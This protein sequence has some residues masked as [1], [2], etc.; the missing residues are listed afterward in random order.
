MSSETNKRLADVERRIAGA[1]SRSGRKREEVTLVAVSKLQ[2][3][4]RV[5]DFIAA[6]Q[7]AGSAVV[8]GENYVQEADEKRAILPAAGK[9][10]MIG[11]LQSNKARRAVAIFDCIETVD[12]EKLAFMLSQ[13]AAKISRRPEV[14]IQVNISG[15]RR[16]AGVAPEQALS[17]AT[18]IVDRCSSV[19]LR[20][21]MTITALHE[22]A[23]E[24]RADFRRMRELRDS[25]QSSPFIRGALQGRMLEL[26]MGMSAD[27]EVAIEEGATLV[28]VGTALFGERQQ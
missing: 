9:L 21:I 1:C 23:E 6:W 10:H 15:D 24:S 17:L 8:L 7:K 14:L 25:L 12:S 3:M 26:S 4:E 18:F 22:A 20:G 16:K 2:S 13:E 19:E 11:K 5:R 27:F 28:R